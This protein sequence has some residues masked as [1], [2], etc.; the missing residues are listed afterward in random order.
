M[1]LGQT[2]AESSVSKGCLAE[3][4]D[5]CSASGRGGKQL[6]ATAEAKLYL[7]REVSASGHGYVGPGQGSPLYF[8]LS[9]G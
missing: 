3:P 7:I 8:L 5:T 4:G 2:G 6:R 1:C 9:L